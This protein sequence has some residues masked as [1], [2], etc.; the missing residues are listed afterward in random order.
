MRVCID[1]KFEEGLPGQ[2]TAAA[3]ADRDSFGERVHFTY[4][5][6]A[7]KPPT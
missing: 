7:G 1:G 5:T 4:T 3:A 6:G 2:A